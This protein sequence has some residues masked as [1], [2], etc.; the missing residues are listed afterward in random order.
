MNY[1][2]LIT[3]LLLLCCMIVTNPARADTGTVDTEIAAAA[4]AGPAEL[5]NLELRA[6]ET[7]KSDAPRMEK[8]HA[9]RILRVIGTVDSIKALGELLADEENSHV[10]RYAME[11]MRYPEADKALRD[12]LAKTSGRVKVGIVNSLAM[13]GGSENVGALLPLL[14]DADD[15]VAGAAAW[16]LGRIG[17]P[18]A[19]SA[20]SECYTNAPAKLKAAAGDGL[21]NAAGQLVANGS[22]AEALAIYKQ[23]LR[24]DAPEH[25]RVGAF[26]GTIEARPDK[27]VD[28]LIEAARSDDWKIRGMAI[29]MVVPLRGMS[30]TERFSYELDK[31]DPE[32]QVL[33]LDALVDRG[34]REGLRSVITKAVSSSNTELRALAIKSL[35][36]MGD[37]GS[38]QVLVKVIETSA[39]E[40]ER[41]LSASSL[42]RLQGKSINSQIVKS[43]KASE[44]ETK[45]QLIE[46]LQDRYAA[47]AVDELLL[48]GSDEDAD[49]R[50][51]ALKALADLAGPEDQK[52]VIGLLVNL[53]DDTGRAEAERAV[54]AVSRKLD[55]AAATEPII[56]A[57]DSA[58]AT[59]C[60]LLRALGGIGDTAS[61]GVVRLALDDDN[62][63][64]CDAAVRTLADWPDATAAR[65]LLKVF[66]TTSNRIHRVVALRGCVRQL[67]AGPVTSDMMLDICTELLEGANRPD[68][69]KLVLACLAKSDEPGATKLIEPLLSDGSVRAEAE[70][71]MLGV[72]RNMTG[73]APQQARAAAMSLRG[74]SQNPSI[75]KQADAV[76]K[77]V[78]KFRDYIM[79]WQVC[80][81]YSR[82][83]ADTFET[84]FGPEEGGVEPV[85]WKPLPIRQSGGKPWMFD[86]R[87]ALGGQRKA[88]YARTWVHSA[89][90][91]PA[92]IEY[93]TD[94]GNKLWLNGK[95]VHA[96]AAGGAAVPGEHKVPITLQKGWN[97]LMLK[98]TQDTGTW[99]FC[100]AIRN[101]TGGKLEGLQIR[102]T[103]PVQ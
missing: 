99:Q 53:K 96:D 88:G 90:E 55:G 28:I 74:R 35:G 82:P 86:L 103:E 57:M 22:L 98:V 64:V 2:R 101:A 54:V 65:T 49:V 20:L 84:A 61:F 10:A 1:Y 3:G 42:R 31:L 63:K 77:L 39:S 91:Q 89:S 38:V 44:S 4:K 8:D 81:P 24:A 48:V 34:E 30:V 93:G 41:S 17:S 58:T 87:A 13:R 67:S 62:E 19:V 51:A 56:A 68:E 66:Q 75:K 78:D 36:D 5:K 40:G 72:I 92:R 37:A 33:M 23:L 59:K 14:K 7:I 79:A 85:V 80:G 52:A 70:L 11:S 18:Q 45:I 60:S 95:L 12:A 76:I 25:V 15:E 71:A 26:A 100:L 102:A 6:I 97:A 29:D 46:I 83:F 43:M 32:T 50:K 47:E 21:L 9:C 16:A 69:K 73:P 94:D 27:A